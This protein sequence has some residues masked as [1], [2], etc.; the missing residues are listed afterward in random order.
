MI[1]TLCEYMS[2]HK[3]D[4]KGSENKKNEEGKVMSEF[5]STFSE[6]MSLKRQTLRV[7][8]YLPEMLLLL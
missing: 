4:Y 1:S 3:Y 7:Y 6:T 8:I 2:L 5:K